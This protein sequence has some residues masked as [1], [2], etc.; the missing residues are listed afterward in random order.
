MSV[1]NVIK[2][3]DPHHSICHHLANMSTRTSSTKQK[4]LAFME[5]ENLFL[6]S[7]FSASGP[8]QSYTNPVD[9]FTSCSSKINVNIIFP[10]KPSS[11]QF[12][13][14]ILY[15]FS[16]PLHILYMPHPHQ[17]WVDCRTTTTIASAA[18]AAT[19]T[20]TT[21]IATS[22]NNIGSFGLCNFL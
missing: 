4:F 7:Q 6:C 2:N 17:P 15:I 10:F 19:T 5:V 21:T 12:S 8:L 22:D 14:K 11:L 18:A 1:G 9:I 20:A 13:T 16:Y 3:C